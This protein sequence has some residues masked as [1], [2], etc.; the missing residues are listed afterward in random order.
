MAL[1]VLAITGCE[2]VFVSELRQVG[3]SSGGLFRD[4]VGSTA[5]PAPVLAGSRYCPT[6]TGY[7]DEDDTFEDH[8]SLSECFSIIGTMAARTDGDDCVIFAD[9]GR[10]SVGLLPTA[11]PVAGFVD[12]ELLFDVV[13]ADNAEL[14]YDPILL[15]AAINDSVAVDLPPNAMPDPDQPIVVAANTTVLLPASLH[16]SRNGEILSWVHESLN[17]VALD[18]EPELL[19]IVDNDPGLAEA[20]EDFPVIRVRMSLGDRIELRYLASGSEFVSPPIEASAARDAASME[21]VAFFDPQVDVPVAIH[22]IIEDTQGRRVVGAPVNWRLIGDGVVASEP[23][24]LARDVLDL[25]ATCIGTAQTGTI[26]ATYGNLRAQ[27]VLRWSC[28][29]LADEPWPAAEPDAIDDDD[30]DSSDGGFDDPLLGCACNNS[31][32]P[33]SIG[34]ALALLMLPLLRRRRR[35]RSLQS[36]H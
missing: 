29:S 3:L 12:D 24:I 35:E 5:G 20:L 36:R 16:D 27:A 30:A 1:G 13:S 17:M 7:F 9:E 33:P 10:A 23:D 2:P 6:I 31:S 32:A 11:C 26:T 8:P 28:S 14:R 25:D 21:L 4:L 15:R 34:G 18:G 22:A 19:P